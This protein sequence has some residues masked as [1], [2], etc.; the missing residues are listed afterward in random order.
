M[1]ISD[2][3]NTIYGRD[4]SFPIVYSW[5]LC[6]KLIDHICVN[7]LLGF[8]SCSFGLCVC[9]DTITILF[10][11]LWFCNIIWN[12]EMCFL[13]LFF[14]K[15]TLAIQDLLWS[16]KNFSIFF[17]IFV[18]NVIGILIG[19]AF[20]VYI[21]L[22]SMDIL[23]ILILPIHELRISFYLFVPSQFLSSMFYSF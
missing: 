22:G 19:I 18:T 5:F 8:L 17:S 4:Y 6:H 10:W 14:L 20:K 11:L 9:F 21:P 2:S 15:I 3:P 16:C 7:L 1:W 12:Q 23:T 13:C